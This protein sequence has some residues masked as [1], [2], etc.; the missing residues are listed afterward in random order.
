MRKGSRGKTRSADSTRRVVAAAQGHIPTE[1]GLEAAIA[2]VFAE[3]Q[4]EGLP[5]DDE[6]GPDNTFV[7]LAE[8]NRLWVSAPAA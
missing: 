2:S 4:A 3:I 8:L 5:D 6:Q 7:L 1:E